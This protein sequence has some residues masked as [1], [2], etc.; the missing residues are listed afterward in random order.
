MQY[1]EFK[2]G[3]R[4]SRLGMGAMRLPVKGNDS[5]I[6]FEKA[7]EI[8]DAAMDSGINYYDTA[9]IYHGGKSE[10]FL[11]EAL[12][13]YP[14]ASFYVADKFNFQADPDYERQFE[15][16]LRRLQMDRIDFYLLHGIQDSFADDI[17]NSG[18]VEYFNRLKGQGKIRYL[19]FSFH[20]SPEALKKAVRYYPWDF[21]QM[22]LNYYDWYC[23]NA[24]EIYQI[25]EEAKIPVMVM[26]PVHGGL[27]ANL[28]A[29][30]AEV[31]KKL[32]P[33]LSLASWAMRWV[34]SRDQVQVVLSGMSDMGQLLDNVETFSEGKTLTGEEET[35]VWEAAMI[36]YRKIA[37][38][39]TSCR[40]CI[41]HCPM[42]LD[43]PFLLRAYNAAKVGGE[44]RLTSLS[45][46][47]E[48]KMPGNCIGCG[49]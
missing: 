27:L 48:A 7:K 9:Y 20:G 34:M 19:G 30:S 46:L 24:E 35:A 25:L 12:K 13:G 42:E 45:A 39:C 44:W 37:V 33:A 32:D 47:P 15:E 22:Q 23:G 31:L 18:C 29:E 8:I 3:I 41:P 5:E 28:T 16:Q 26:E 36:Q 14:R 11:G 49:A 38:P 2:D 17:L 40:Y 6:D 10:A 43:I 21:V 1:M 4:L